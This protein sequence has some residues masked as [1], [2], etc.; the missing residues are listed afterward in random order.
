MAAAAV[1][2]ND[3]LL[4][5]AQFFDALR[6]VK[7]KKTKL[8]YP[9]LLRFTFDGKEFET[10]FQINYKKYT[11][12]GTITNKCI[13]LD[14]EFTS[15]ISANNPEKGCFRPLLTHE[16]LKDISPVTPTDVLQVLSTKLKFAG[17]PEK[18]VFT[19]D[20][21]ARVS[22]ADGGFYQTRISHWRLLRGE[23]TLYEKYGYMPKR[24]TGTSF[25]VYRGAVQSITWG[26]IMNYET[27]TG[28]TLQAIADANFPEGTFVSDQSIA[29]CMKKVTLAMADAYIQPPFPELY[30][31]AKP[32]VE[33]IM[34]ALESEKH[35]PKPTFVLSVHRDS[36]T[37]KAWDRRLVFFSFAPVAAATVTRLDGR[38]RRI[39]RK[40]R[41]NIH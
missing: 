33:L 40:R 30:L 23:P 10:I 8:N 32:F 31:G 1:N 21:T 36:K 18:K 41:R 15:S 13:L 9:Y 5:Q 37:W 25:D 29:E 12:E 26:E 3:D 17:N 4:S 16:T 27:Q 19:I 28:M 20:D 6:E 24:T 39:T 34:D 11:N 22:K 2:S 38:R 7:Q 35:L 14:F